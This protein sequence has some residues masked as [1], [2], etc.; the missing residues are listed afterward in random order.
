[1]QRLRVAVP[2]TTILAQ[3][4]ADP[5]KIAVFRSTGKH[6]NKL[7][8]PGGKVRIGVENHLDTGI[9]ESGEEISAGIID[10][11]FFCI[12]DNPL[13]DVRKTTLGKLSEGN[14]N[15]PEE[16]KNVEVDGHYCFDV[17]IY[18]VCSGEPAV[19]QE[20]GSE[21]I[22]Y[23]LRTL[24]PGEFALDHGFLALQ[25][26]RFLETGILPPLGTL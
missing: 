1:M 8:I 16:F 3:H 23:D 13:R 2:T 22:W 26:K 18:G 17:S 12:S 15:F 24:Q 10:P 19:D 11:K 20:E 14:P 7:V 25:F 4:P 9:K 21:V 5:F 6:G